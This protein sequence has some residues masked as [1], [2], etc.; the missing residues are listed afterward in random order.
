MKQVP[1]IG[2]VLDLIGLVVFLGGGAVFV[3]SWFGFESVR[4]Y[5]PKATD[6]IGSATVL[7]NSFRHLQRVGGTLM[8]LGIAVFVVAWWVARRRSNDDASAT[9]LSDSPA[10]ENPRTRSDSLHGESP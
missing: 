3:R 5:Q 4:H 6:P 2:R 7:A 9:P 10:P 1:R 8:A